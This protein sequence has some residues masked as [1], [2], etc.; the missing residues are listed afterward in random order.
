MLE[1]RLSQWGKQAQQPVG[2]IFW[3]TAEINLVRELA[4]KEG[5]SAS[6]IAKTISRPFRVRSRKSIYSIC[7]EQGIKL[8]G[9]MGRPLGLKTPMTSTERTRNWRLRH[10]KV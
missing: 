4:E 7:R 3:T 8:S 9:E 2:K 1:P 5:L 6:R 10:A